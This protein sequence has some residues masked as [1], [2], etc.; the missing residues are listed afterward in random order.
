[1]GRFVKG[2]VVIVPFPFSDLTGT[3]RRPALVVAQLHGDDLV[4]CQITSVNR[5]DEYAVQ[6]S[7]GDFVSGGL[8]KPSF[9]SSNRIFT[10]DSAL[11]MDSVGHISQGKMKEVSD[12]LIAIFSQ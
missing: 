5:G 12:K 9:I 11:I 8:S 3:K 7:A 10:A 2:E 4:L 1:M 6:L